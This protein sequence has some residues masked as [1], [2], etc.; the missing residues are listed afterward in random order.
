M[1]GR[2]YL[3]IAGAIAADIAAGRLQPGTRLPPQRAL[4]DALGIDFTT[5]TRAYAEAGKRGLVEGRVG[6]GTYVRLR[7]S[8]PAPAAGRAVDISMNLP[9]RFE[10]AA[11]NA[12]MQTGIKTVSD[13]GLDLLLAYQDPGGADWIVRRARIGFNPVCPASRRSGSPF[14]PAPKARW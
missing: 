5:V 3:A 10:D 6:H 14:V 4:A 11:L 7:Q 9:P 1:A 2:F 8:R 13:E 12:R